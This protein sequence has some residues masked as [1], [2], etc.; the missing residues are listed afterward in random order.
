MNKIEFI[1]ALKKHLNKIPRKELDEILM[2]YE[3]HFR[4]GISEAKTEEEISIH[5]GDV[6]QI[7]DQF[8]NDIKNDEE[9][10][11]DSKRNIFVSILIGFGMLLFNLIFL[12]GIFFGLLGA[13]I[14]LFAA[15]IGIFAGGLGSL[16]FL[17]FSPILSIYFNIDILNIPLIIFA[18]IGLISLGAMFFIG[19]CYVAKYFFKVVW[20]YLKWNIKVIKN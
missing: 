18:S 1:K 12:S 2:D 20:L 8:R 6:K 17:L 5:L 4:I 3:E 13:L 19:N 10:I 7:A 11:K 14:G 9:P 16:M 15:S